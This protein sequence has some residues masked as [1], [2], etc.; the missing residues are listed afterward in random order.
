MK[1]PVVRPH[2]WVFLCVPKEI[3]CQLYQGFHFEN[4]ATTSIQQII[5]SLQ[6]CEVRRR[7]AALQ[8]YLN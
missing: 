2:L 7:A 6:R 5:E 3:K 1:L 8:F 4:G